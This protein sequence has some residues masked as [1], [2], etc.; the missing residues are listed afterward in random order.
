MDRRAERAAARRARDRRGFAISA[1]STVVVLGGLAA[2][3]LTSP[4]WPDVRDSFFNWD[5]FTD[6]FPDVLEA[7]WLDIKILTKT[8]PVVM[9]GDNTN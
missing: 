6:T 5:V 8:L 2:L 3:I 7:F 9:R 4:G 1:I